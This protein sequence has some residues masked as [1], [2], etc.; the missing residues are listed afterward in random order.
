MKRLF[1]FL[2]TVASFLSAQEKESLKYLQYDTDLLPAS[3]FKTRRDSVLHMLG[4]DAAAVFYAAPE[5][6]RNGDVDYLYR[7]ADNFY[8][9]TGCT[10]PN[11]LLILSPKGIKVKTGDSTTVTANE[12]LFVQARNPQMESWTGRRLGVEGAMALL[13]FQAAQTNDQFKMT[14]NRMLFSGIK[15]LYVPS[16]TT[17]ITGDLRDLIAPIVSYID[18]QKRRNSKVELRDPTAMVNIL[19][20]IKSPAEIAMLRT[21]SEISATAH[22]QAMMSVEPGMY[23]YEMQA[24]YEYAFRRQGAEYDGYPCI[25]GAAENS[26]ILHYNSNRKKMNAG[27]I[28]LNDCAAEYRGYS[29]DVTRTFPVN[30]TFSK[31]QKEIYQLVLNAQKAAIV[32]IRPGVS[33]MEVSAAADSVIS[34]GLFALGITKQKEG[35]GFRKFFNHGLGHP[36]GLNVHDVGQMNLVPGMLYTVEPG[37]YIPEKAD[38]VAQKYWNIGVRIEDVILVTEKGNENLSASAPREIAEIE[39]LMKKKGIGNQP[40]K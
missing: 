19:R 28:V 5:R 6:M 12:V 15:Y 32:K 37:I 7:Q 35:Q 9:L 21:A 4:P 8:Y 36:V 20:V 40:L 23:E 3:E 33:W 38:S 34:E 11:A 39:A 16:V 31:E 26:V 14:F 10:E 18:N 2:V 1:L 22:R 30:G 29:S 27:E 17:D 13:G 24:L 25:D